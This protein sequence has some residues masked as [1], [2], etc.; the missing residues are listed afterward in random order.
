MK[1]RYIVTSRVTEVER[2]QIRAAAESAGQTVSDW[3]R[4]VAM[5]AALPVAAPPTQRAA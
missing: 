5:A 1:R 2:A 3:L 4:A